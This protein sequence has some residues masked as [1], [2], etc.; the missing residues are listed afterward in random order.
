MSLI[1]PDPQAVTPAQ[2]AELGSQVL[3]AAESTNDAHVVTD[4]SNKWAAIT[5]YLR[6]TSTEGIAQ[7][8]ATKLR[9]VSRIGALSPAIPNDGGRINP[10]AG[11][12][13]PMS[14][15]R[16][17]EARK[18]AA[19]TDV[20]DEV[21]EQ[22]TDANPPTKAKALREIAK[23]SAQA[24]AAEEQAEIDE[25]YDSLDLDPDFDHSDNDRKWEVMHTADRF[26]E[27]VGRFY[28][29]IDDIDD[30]AAAAGIWPDAARKRFDERWNTA[31]D[32]LEKLNVRKLQ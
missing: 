12:D 26:A 24:D 2:V 20:V 11:I 30:I 17:T 7:A 21:I 14:R 18:L 6:R 4:L 13:H 27:A 28:A 5:E 29:E 16:M 9:L 3:A 15:N 8:E 19:N 32:Q 1:L 25:F 23:R 22:S 31:V 10:D